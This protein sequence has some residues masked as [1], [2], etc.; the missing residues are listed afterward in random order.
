MSKSVLFVKNKRRKRKLEFNVKRKA[1]QGFNES[2]YKNMVDV[3]DYKQLAIFLDDL[4]I[5]FNAPLDK[6]M[7]E[8]RNKKSPFW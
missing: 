1:N 3:T 4:E 8:L 5:L 2:E 7:K 6:A